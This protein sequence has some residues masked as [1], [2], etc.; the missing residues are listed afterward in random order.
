MYIR[1]WLIKII[2]SIDKS[3]DL[4]SFIQNP[5]RNSG[6]TSEDFLEA[7]VDGTSSH[8]IEVRQ[9]R[10]SFQRDIQC[11]GRRIVGVQSPE[12]VGQWLPDKKLST[13]SFAW[14]WQW[15]TARQQG[16]RLTDRVQSP[17]ECAGERLSRQQG[18]RLT[19]R[20]QSPE[21]CAGERLSRQQ[22]ICLIVVSRD[23]SVSVNDFPTTRHPPHRCVQRP[24]CVRE[25]YC[26][27]ILMVLPGELCYVSILWTCNCVVYVIL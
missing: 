14:V 13:L 18:I 26:W 10:R 25:N 19:D 2:L 17:E 15:T 22:G 3:R 23:R 24:E 5:E 20:V 11:P 7:L 6:V 16:I 21:E 27:T 1:C 12:C 4:S 8:S 9:R